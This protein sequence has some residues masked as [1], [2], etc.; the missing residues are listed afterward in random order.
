[1]TSPPSTPWLPPLCLVNAAEHGYFGWNV[2]VYQVASVLRLQYMWI[3]SSLVQEIL[4]GRE[5]GITSFCFLYPLKQKV[6]TSSKKIHSFLQNS[7]S[8]AVVPEV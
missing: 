6:K 8:S 4:S 3:L 2:F 5:G 1:M 7:L